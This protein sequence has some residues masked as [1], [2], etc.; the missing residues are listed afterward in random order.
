MYCSRCR[1]EDYSDWHDR[2][3]GANIRSR[4]CTNQHDGFESKIQFLNKFFIHCLAKCVNWKG[5]SQKCIIYSDKV[6]LIIRCGHAV[7]KI[8]YLMIKCTSEVREIVFTGVWHDVR[9]LYQKLRKKPIGHIDYLSNNRY[10][11]SGWWSYNKYLNK[12]V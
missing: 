2:I 8:N 4:E 12:V 1:S 11:T 7:L 5:K 6:V 3:N 9:L 10:N